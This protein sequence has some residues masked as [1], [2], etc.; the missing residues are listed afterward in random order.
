MDTWKAIFKI[1]EKATTSS[2]T[3]LHLACHKALIRNICNIEE[4]LSEIGKEA[5]CKQEQL[6]NVTLAITSKE[7]TTQAAL[8]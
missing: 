7:I 1:W 3:D 2:P 8:S 6:L 5:A 4:A